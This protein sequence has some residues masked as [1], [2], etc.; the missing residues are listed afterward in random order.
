MPS[1][2]LEP[3]NGST[4]LRSKYRDVEQNSKKMKEG[5]HLSATCR[6]RNLEKEL[7][8]IA[9]AK[10]TSYIPVITWKIHHYSMTINVFVIQ[11]ARTDEPSSILD[12]FSGVQLL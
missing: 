6:C 12:T 7:V 5:H 10:V 2:Q 3:Y 1:R 8:K 9:H 11:E 4:A